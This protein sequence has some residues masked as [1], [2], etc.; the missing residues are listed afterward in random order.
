MA[1]N[2]A[3]FRFSDFAQFWDHKLSLFF[4]AQIKSFFR[5]HIKWNIWKRYL[6]LH[7]RQQGASNTTG[8][9]SR[10]CRKYGQIFINPKKRMNRYIQLIAILVNPTKLCLA[11]KILFL[12]TWCMFFFLTGSD[13]KRDI[14]AVKA[15]NILSFRNQ[16]TYD[17]GLSTKPI[18]LIWRDF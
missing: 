18:L 13:V 4:P 12:L 5:E 16:L 2:S 11:S 7:L 17:V 10:N 6:H 8:A 1:L 14:I 15:E 9:K 3:Y